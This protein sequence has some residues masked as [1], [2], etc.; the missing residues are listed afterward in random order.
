MAQATRRRA[1]LPPASTPDVPFC[2]VA[3]I[4][5]TVVPA[6]RSVS[7]RVCSVVGPKTVDGADRA[8][9]R[10]G[11]RVNFRRAGRPPC[12]PLLL[13]LC[14]RTSGMPAERRTA[15]VCRDWP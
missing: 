14:D 15:A 1:C 4:V 11:F 8:G 3:G 10:M 12:L 2:A 7:M 9:R 6:R 5:V 13:H